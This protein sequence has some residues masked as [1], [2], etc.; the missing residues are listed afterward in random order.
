MAIA[1]VRDLG[2]IRTS[3][4][5]LASSASFGTAPA[6]NNHIVSTITCYK[7]GDTT[8][9]MT[10]S[11]NQSNS[12]T[13]HATA[14]D[15]YSGG[16]SI[17]NIASAKVTTSS[18]TFTV[19]A[20]ASG[21]SVAY[22]TW[23]ATEFSGMHATTWLDRTGTVVGTPGVNNTS[24]TVTT[25]LNLTANDEC[26]VS[27]LNLFSFTTHGSIAATGY[28]NVFSEGDTTTY[29]GG[30]GAYKLISGGTGA[31]HSAAWSWTTNVLGC[32]AVIA[33][34]IPAAGGSYSL[35]AAQGSYALTGQAVGVRAARKLVAAQGNYTLTGQAVALLRK[36]TLAAVKGDYTLTG[37]AATLLA[38]RRLA[39][40][41]GT[42]ALTGI[43]QALRVSRKL[44][45]AVGNYTLT[46][47]ATGL[48]KLSRITCAYGTYTWNGS[49]VTLT[50]S[51]A[52]PTV[53]SR[54]FG[55]RKFQQFRSLFRRFGF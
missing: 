19:T 48:K 36:Y 44:V 6:V 4:S 28:T 31:T 5:G 25:S 7:S 35:T 37:Q 30:A 15:S 40:D 17:S 41:F 49:S 20:T 54:I 53:I 38:P 11:D 16:E 1:Y 10:T 24:V 2:K 23:S 21:S 34:F 14:R 39:A 33:T 12:Y 13:S 8:Y 47:I 3:G 50:Y 46:G 43:A 45:A 18:G 29:I 22:H 27:A 52:P 42:Y 26:A 51:A 55:D 32:A 9:T